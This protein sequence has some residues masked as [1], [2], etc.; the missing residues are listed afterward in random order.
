MCVASL[1]APRCCVSQL[2][3]RALQ[4]RRS[5][6]SAAASYHMQYPAAATLFLTPFKHQPTS[7]THRGPGLGPT[8]VLERKKG[9]QVDHHCEPNEVPHT[10]PDPLA[11]REEGQRLQARLADGGATRACGRGPAVRGELVDSNAAQRVGDG[12][13]VVRPDPPG[14]NGS[15]RGQATG[16]KY[17]TVSQWVVQVG[18]LH[19]LHRH[20]RAPT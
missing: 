13:D 16:G 18:M 20:S 7:H 8:V 12:A 11:L 1:Q 14:R 9:Q 19:R 4:H 3:P 10:D 5:Q 17:S 2:S 6:S 15:C